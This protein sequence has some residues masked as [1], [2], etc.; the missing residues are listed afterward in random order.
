M[1]SALSCGLSWAC[2]APNAD[3]T[4]SRA[5]WKRSC[6]CDTPHFALH[7]KCHEG[8]GSLALLTNAGHV[9]GLVDFALASAGGRVI[10]HSQLYPRPDDTATTTWSQIGAALIP[11]AMPAVHPK[12]NKVSLGQCLPILLLDWLE[13]CVHCAGNKGLPGWCQPPFHYGVGRR[14]VICA[15]PSGGW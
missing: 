12:A 8:S 6:K 14:S 9:Q 3:R 1:C 4:I 11:G 5:G 15:G 13:H 7:P 2:P 10:G